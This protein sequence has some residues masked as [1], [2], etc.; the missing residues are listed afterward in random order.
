MAFCIST[1]QQTRLKTKKQG[2]VL[3]EVYC[4][5]P[6]CEEIKENK[7]NDFIRMHNLHAKGWQLQLHLQFSTVI[8]CPMYYTELLYYFWGFVWLHQL[9]F[10]HQW[11][12]KPWSPWVSF[13]ILLLS[14]RNK[15]LIINVNVWHRLRFCR[16]YSSFRTIS[17]SNPGLTR[18]QNE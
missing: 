5:P 2:K 6:I 10:R 4:T 3:H 7:K 15:L 1:T 16:V 18:Q 14:S 8:L 11:R 13:R 9:P 12:S 17:H